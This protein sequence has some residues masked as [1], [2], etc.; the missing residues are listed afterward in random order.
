M[1]TCASLVTA[2]S[3]ID[4]KQKVQKVDIIVEIEDKEVDIYRDTALRY[5]GYLNEIG[6]NIVN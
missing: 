3:V 2:G 4:Q 1:T 5:A 6:T